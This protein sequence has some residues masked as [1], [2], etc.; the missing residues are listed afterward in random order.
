VKYLKTYIDKDNS[1][2]ID[3][4]DISLYI[5]E[6]IEL[7]LTKPYDVEHSLYKTGDYVC[8]SFKIDERD[9][10]V[11]SVVIRNRDTSCI[12][13]GKNYKTLADYISQ[14]GIK[15]DKFLFIGFGEYVDGVYNYDK[16]VNDY[17]TLFRKMST[18]IKI[19]KDMVSY[20]KIN[21]IILNSVDNDIKSGLVKN[22]NKRDKFYELFLAYYN[23][24][25]QKIKHS[26]D[27]NGEVVSNF[28][29]LEY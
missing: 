12:N 1:E 10:I 4:S 8:S 14:F 2:S 3:Y 11:S 18:V 22:Y 28:L 21:F 9:V 13:D 17:N 29:L 23:I 15:T 16:N 25:Y 7:G 27:I 6:E 24:K 26:I 5:R 20:H 19:I